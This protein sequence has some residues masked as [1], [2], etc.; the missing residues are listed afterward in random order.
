MTRYREEVYETRAFKA[1]LARGEVNSQF[2]VSGDAGASR[3][4]Y[5]KKTP[6]ARRAINKAQARLNGF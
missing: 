3:A 2:T 5:F 6:A 4:Q 1:A